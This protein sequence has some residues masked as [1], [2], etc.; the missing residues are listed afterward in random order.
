[1]VASAWDKVCLARL[2][3][4]PTTLDYIELIFDDFIELHGDRFYSDDKA[5]V[6]GIARLNGLPVTVIGHQKG[7][8]TQTRIERNFGMA[9]PEGY[10]KALRLMKQAEKFHRPIITFIDTPGA[11]CGIGA[12]ERGEAESIARNLMEMANLKVPIL[13]IVIGEGSSGGALG[14]GVGNRVFMLENAV[15]SV[16]SP[17]GFSTILWK[18]SSRAKEAADIMKITAEDLLKLKVIDGIIKEPEGGAHNDKE[19]TAKN[20]KD[21]IERELPKLLT[22]S[23]KELQEDRYQKFRRIPDSEYRFLEEETCKETVE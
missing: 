22:M 16:L 8:T 20:M 3:A 7:R 23:A 21:C 9:N 18:D 2:S 19:M 5:I 11:Y 15:Y 14:L 17:E 12:E 4:R 10:R 13:C 6:G 1:M